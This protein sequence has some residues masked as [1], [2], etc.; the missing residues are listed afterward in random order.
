MGSC[1]QMLAAWGWT[2]LIPLS[3]SSV[4][5]TSE[6]GGSSVSEYGLFCLFFL[7][8]CIVSPSVCFYQ[9]CASILFY[10]DKPCSSIAQ[11]EFSGAD[12]CPAPS[13][14]THPGLDSA[15]G[16]NQ[17]LEIK[18]FSILRRELVSTAM[19]YLAAL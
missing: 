2:F 16:E 14:S 4:V 13:G 1:L 17:V 8:L 6:K 3:S 11:A 18:Y 15:A 9:T 19:I 12:V 5:S 7:V 10:K